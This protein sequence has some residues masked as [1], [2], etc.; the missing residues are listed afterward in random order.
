M[1]RI[2]HRFFT[3]VSIV[4]LSFL[5]VDV[6]KAC[7]CLEETPLDW[8]TKASE[9]ILLL[10]FVA[11]E[12]DKSVE[13]R[14]N[15]DGITQSKLVVQK[16]LKG[17]MKKGQELTFPQGETS[18]DWFFAE[19]EIGTEFIFFLGKNIGSQACS[20]SSSLKF[21][22][23]D[24]LYLE[25]YQKVLGKTRLSGIVYNVTEGKT[26]NP[27]WKKWNYEPIPGR[28]VRV[29]G[30]GINITLKTNKNG[31][32]EVYDLPVGK[33]KII[34]HEV[35]GY[36]I[37]IPMEKIDEVEIKANSLTKQNIEYLVN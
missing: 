22:A 20:R 1:R 28:K 31:A 21:A 7:S 32:Y 15:P 25:K 9:D 16:S 4:F 11:V 23:D 10:K 27:M 36:R 8:W 13:N 26:D 30:N 17:S 37:L 29:Q 2:F 34:P 35:K 19:N 33:Y 12:K 18:C 6:A 3:F 24:L 14:H 5:L